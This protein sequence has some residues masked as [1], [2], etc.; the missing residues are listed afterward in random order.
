[1]YV[2]GPLWTIVRDQHAA[3]HFQIIDQP[4]VWESPNPTQDL[5]LATQGRYRRT[6]RLG[7]SS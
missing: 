5:K 7:L 3:Q 6:D 1:M 4:K 2:P